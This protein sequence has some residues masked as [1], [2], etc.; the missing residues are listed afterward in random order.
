MKLVLVR[1]P[2]ESDPI[3]DNTL[4]VVYNHSVIAW[5]WY[6]WYIDDNAARTSQQVIS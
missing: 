6:Q 3:E 2:D 4:D 5:S 1:P